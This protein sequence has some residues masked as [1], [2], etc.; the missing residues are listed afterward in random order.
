MNGK[1][2]HDIV[3]L[4]KLVLAAELVFFYLLDLCESLQEVTVCQQGRLGLVL[5]LLLR[6]LFC[7]SLLPDLPAS[8]IVL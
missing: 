6:L 7:F 1:L 3:L 5:L 4:V 2:L 8:I